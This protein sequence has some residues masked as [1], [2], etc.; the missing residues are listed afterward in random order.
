MSTLEARLLEA[1]ARDDRAALVELYTE[2]GDS[3]SDDRA[4]Y[5]YLTHA[6]VFALELGDPRAAPLHQRLKEAGREA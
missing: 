5:F 3:T 1:H 6:F 2:A 4:R